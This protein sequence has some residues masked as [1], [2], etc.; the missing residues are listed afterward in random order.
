MSVYPTAQYAVLESKGIEQ[1]L[2]VTFDG[3]LHQLMFNQDTMKITTDSNPQQLHT[4]TKNAAFDLQ[5]NRFDKNVLGILHPKSCTVFRLNKSASKTLVQ[6]QCPETRRSFSGFKFLSARSLAIWTTGGTAYLYYLGLLQMEIGLNDYHGYT[7][8][9]IGILKSGN[10]PDIHSMPVTVYRAVEPIRCTKSYD[11]SPISDATSQHVPPFANV[12][13]GEPVWVQYHS[14][15]DIW[16]VKHMSGTRHVCYVNPTKHVVLGHE[17][18]SIVVNLHQCQSSRTYM[19]TMYTITTIA[20]R[21]SRHNDESH[22]NGD[23][24]PIRMMCLIV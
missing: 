6:I 1:V 21:S 20:A 11:T 14:F 8:T 13:L 18:G 19:T 16:P 15:E 4:N 10:D 2:V 23:Y 24:I 9:C 12:F 17:D 3:W 7:A 5:H 22:A